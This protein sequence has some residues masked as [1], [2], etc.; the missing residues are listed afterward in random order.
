VIVG[1]ESLAA[2]GRVAGADALG[3]GD[4]E[5]AA[6]IVEGEAAWIPA[7][8]QKAPNLGPL[9]H[10]EDADGVVRAVGDEET[11]AVF[12]EYESVGGAAK[13]HVLVRAHRELTQRLACR[14]VDDRD[15]VAVGV[16][17]VEQAALFVDRQI[18]RM[19]S[20]LEVGKQLAAFELYK[21]QRARGRD[22][23][24]GI[25]DDL[26]AR[27]VVGDIAFLGAASSPVGDAERALPFG[28]GVRCDTDRDLTDQLAALDIDDADG[29]VAAQ[30]D[31]ERLCVLHPDPAGAGA[32]FASW[33]G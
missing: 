5:P 11:L 21:A 1:V 14:E 33:S 17:H 6:A 15:R 3:I 7:D 24:D 22:V 2:G 29:V 4:V 26:R 28:Q 23:G 16:G 32:A 27:G 31:V 20:D 18:A 30:G 9:A 12:A 8:R 10:V 13:G 25:Y 19:Q